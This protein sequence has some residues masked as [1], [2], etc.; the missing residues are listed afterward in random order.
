MNPVPVP[1]GILVFLSFGIIVLV[2]LWFRTQA[3]LAVHRSVIAT[4]DHRLDVLEKSTS[5]TATR[6]TSTRAA[7]TALRREF[8]AVQARLE[9]LQISIAPRA[10]KIETGESLPVAH[11]RRINEKKKKQE[12]R[13]ALERV[14]SDDEIIEG[15]DE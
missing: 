15:D 11:R 5:S 14:A 13:T 7:T 12:A 1:I 8:R 2:V 9:A 4:L 3:I 10:L 6:S